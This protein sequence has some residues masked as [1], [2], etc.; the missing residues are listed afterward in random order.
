[1]TMI[2]EIHAH[3]VLAI[4]DASG[5]LYDE[6]GLEAKLHETYGSGC[7]YYACSASGMDAAALIAFLF[8]KEK[9]TNRSGRLFLSRANPC[10]H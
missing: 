10:G 4:I 9:I 6:A 7:S 5:G 2:K 3:D 8:R 1:M